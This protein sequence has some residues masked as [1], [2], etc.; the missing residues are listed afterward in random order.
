MQRG[1]KKRR[2]TVVFSHVNLNCVLLSIR[3][4]QKSVFYNCAGNSNA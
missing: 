3:K 4:R 1:L 2:G